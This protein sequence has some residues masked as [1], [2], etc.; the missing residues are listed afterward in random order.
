MTKTI[1][2]I[3]LGSI[4]MRHAKNLRALGQHVWGLDPDMSKRL[5]LGYDY[6]NNKIEHMQSADAFIIASP[7]KTHADYLERLAFSG[8]PIFIEKPVADRMPIGMNGV[9]MVGYNLRHH[10]CV[11]QAKEW[12]NAGLIGKP[13]WANFTCGQFNDRPAYLRDGV[14]LNW[15]HEID[16]ALYLIGDASVAAS[17]T[18]LTDGEDD[19]TDILLTHENGCRSAIHLDYMTETEQRVF[20]ITGAHG[21]IEIDIVE[22]KAILRPDKARFDDTYLDHFYG[23]D[24]FDQNY[25]EE[26]KAFLDRIDGKQT[27]GCTGA[28]GL[29]VLEICLEVRKQAGLI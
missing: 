1:C 29:S 7:T 24:S 9:V 14:I 11:K 5:D 2:V 22:R 19:M 18:R 16:L 20:K 28:E 23:D 13:L 3:G 4:G 26:I 15:S 8:K 25:I 27:I 6:T 17:S 12:L 21:S 10:S